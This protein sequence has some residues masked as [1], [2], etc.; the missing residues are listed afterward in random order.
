[1]SKETQERINKQIIEIVPRQAAYFVD[2]H[3]I[4]INTQAAQNMGVVRIQFTAV[5]DT[6]EIPPKIKGKFKISPKAV[7]DDIDTELEDPTQPTLFE[8]AVLPVDAEVPH[9]ES[10]DETLTEPLPKKKRTR[11]LKGAQPA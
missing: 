3:I 4:E 1:M 5:I 7:T 2:K 10:G 11:K 8:Q 9:I 6:T